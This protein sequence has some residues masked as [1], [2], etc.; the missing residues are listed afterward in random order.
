MTELPSVTPRARLRLVDEALLR[1][2][3]PFGR[4]PRLGAIWPHTHHSLFNQRVVAGPVFVCR[5]VRRLKFLEAR[6]NGFVVARLKFGT[7]ASISC[8]LAEPNQ[9]FELKRS[10]EP[11]TKATPKQRAMEM[12]PRRI[13]TPRAAWNSEI[14]HASGT[15]KTKNSV[16][17]GMKIDRLPRPVD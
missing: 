15:V 12:Q 7:I 11:T 10:N 6:E 14:N 13:R 16:I 9:A 2:A 8:L 1:V 17:R 5:R 4:Y 3:G